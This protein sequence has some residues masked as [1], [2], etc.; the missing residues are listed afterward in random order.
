MAHLLRFML[1][2][3]LIAMIAFSLASTTWHGVAQAASHGPAVQARDAQV[4]HSQADHQHS[5]SA[6]AH[7]AGQR[8]CHP[9]CTMA[10]APSPAIPA[11]TFLFSASLPVARDLMPVPIT[12]SSLDHP[13]KRT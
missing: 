12:P 10:T 11:Q 6:K 3:L 13:P 2:R 7:A 5:A 4:R 1:S 9:A 8:H